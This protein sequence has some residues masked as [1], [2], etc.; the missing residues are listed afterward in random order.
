MKKEKGSR[1][2]QKALNM[3]GGEG[4]KRIL[5]KGST[6]G[7]SKPEENT[8]SRGNFCFDTRKMREGK[9]PEPMGQR[10]ATE[11]TAR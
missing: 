6:T 10:G 9:V 3:E 1:W 2:K 5:I 11:S 8:M 4:K 7:S